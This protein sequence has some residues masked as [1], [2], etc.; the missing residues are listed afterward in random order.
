MSASPQTAT[1]PAPGANASGVDESAAEAAR[2]KPIGTAE[3]R[4]SAIFS[5]DMGLQ[6]GKPIVLFGTGTP[7]R[8]VVTVLSTADGSALIRR[9]SSRS[10]TD[11]VSAIGSIAPDGTW[12]VTLPPLEA[13]G[14]YTLTISDRTSVTLKYFNVMV[15][16]VWIASG[17]SN[18]EFELHN[19]RDADSAI[20]ASDDPLLRFFNVPKF[21]VVDSELIAAENQSAWRAS[22]PDSCS[23]MS[24]IAYYFAR[25]LRRDLG[26]DVPV[27]IVDCYIGGTSITSWMSE[28]MLT[29]TEAG[30]GYLDRYHQQ[31]DG[32]TDQQFHDETDSWQCTF[33]AWNEQIAAAQA[34]EPDITW[35]VLNA[36]YGEC[37]WPPPVTPF[38]QYHVTGAFNAMVRR[39]APFSTRGVLWYQGEED[40]QRYAS[41]RELLGCMI[42]EWRTLWSR[43]AGG[44]FSDS[45]DV[46]RIVADDAARGHGAEPIADTP[47]ASVGNEAELPFIIVQLPRW[48]D[49]K[50]YNSGIDRMFW[51]HIREAQADAARIIPDV[52]LAVTFDTGEF[53]NIHPTDKRPVGERIALQA[54]AH[55]YGLPVH[56]DGPAF[57]SLAS[58]GEMADEL[59]V[60]FDNADGLHFGP[61]SGSD[62]V[63]HLPAVHSSESGETEPLWTVNR[64][65]AAAS[66]FEI[67]GS[68]GIYHRADARIEADTVVLHAD[69]VS[70]PICARYGWFSWGP[71]PL[72]NAFGLPAAPFRIHK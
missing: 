64:C 9:Q 5:H 46:G 7:G 51:P 12:M 60:R 35:D 55:V 66:G 42:G 10:I 18:I 2:N 17:Q 34:A 11:S 57:V 3:F 19:D 28:H 1:G 38:S 58:A 69:A 49:Q 15:G 8:P 63:G 26:P 67:A 30:R 16:E 56:A 71:A 54:E 45:Y 25:K 70:H 72:F 40:E 59:Q 65:D 47:A 44:D 68:D 32:K 31:I 21:G 39:L 4:P 52:Y 36:R 48:I 37:P 14:P 23:T 53:N 13:G 22:S 20:A 61:W 62:D 50:E 27:G 33:N 41:Y 24:A 6:R 29:A 43:R